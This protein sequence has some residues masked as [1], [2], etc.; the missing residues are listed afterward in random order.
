M[1]LASSGCAPI[2]E[3]DRRRGLSAYSPARTD[4]GSTMISLG[5]PRSDDPCIRV[6]VLSCGAASCIGRSW[7]AVLHG[8]TE[9]AI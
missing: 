2:P 5:P 8:R 9:T 4:G 3:G 6:P 1:L 7:P